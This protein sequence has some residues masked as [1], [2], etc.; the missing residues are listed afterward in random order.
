MPGR[1]SNMFFREPP[2]RRLIETAL[3]N[4]SADLVIRGGT[5]LDV[6]SGRVVEGRS[7][8]VVDRWIAYVGPDAGHAVGSATRVVEATG[9]ILA[10]GYMDTHT[11]LGSYWNIADFLHYAIPG[12]TTTFITELE[13]AGYARGAEGVKAFLEQL[14]GRPVK[15]FCTIPPMVTLSPAL[16]SLYISLEQ[17]RDLLREELV[18]G[19]G[20]S[21]WQEVVLTK[22]HRVLELMQETLRAGKSVQGHAA[23]AFDRKLAAYAAA[24]AMSCHE[25]ITPE[26]V[27]SRL[28]L[29]LYVMVREGEIRRDL[30]ILLPIKDQ[31]DFRRVILVTDQTNPD[32]LIRNGYLVDV[33]QKAVDKGLDPVR[34]I[35]TVTI[36][37][38]EHFGIDHITGGIAPGRLADILILPSLGTMKPDVV[39]SEGRIIAENGRTSVPIDRVPYPP[40]FFRTVR[41]AP[42]SPSDLAIPASVASSTGTVRTI[43]IQPGG[44]VSREG[45]ARP[46]GDGGFLIGVPEEDLLKVV[47]IER[48]TGRGERFSGFVRGWGQREGSVASTLCWEAT[49]IIAVGADDKDLSTAIN[50]VIE[51]QGGT[52]LSVRGEVRVEIPFS[53]LGF[54]SEL[55][56]KEIASGIARFQ[57][58]LQGLGSRF[59]N[60]HLSLLVLTT[61]AIPFI[62]M[63]EKGYYRFREKDYVGV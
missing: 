50:R 30:E 2:T 8:A 4:E 10:P 9:R 39:I 11:H 21:Y 44:L 60:P 53:A 63:S 7:V 28:E 18:L 61:A 62:R 27:L 5:L 34:V 15:F 45:R 23:G 14:R 55:P 36:N 56:I 31:I 59:D 16:R 1:I 22:D 20:E 33:L 26:D 47:F 58:E 12:G 38:A 40:E 54:L 6:Y 42:V 57:R 48:I 17:A 37:P 43:D 24:G 51:M 13:S 32:L 41:I 49:G 46:G 29:G 35:Q 3:G 19:L 52:V 25:S